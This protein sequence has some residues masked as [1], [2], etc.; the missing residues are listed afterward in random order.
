M[1]DLIREHAR[2]LAAAWTPPMTGEQATGRLLD[3]YQHTAARAD[4]LL[5]RHARGAAAP[6]AGTA[7]AAS[8][9]WPAGN[10]R[11]RGP[12]PSGPACW[13]AWTRPPR[14]ASTPGSSR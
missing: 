5:A 13:P 14:P 2:A 9:S 7:P 11:W 10:R 1:H 6:A 8:R 3:Y 4:A 12:A